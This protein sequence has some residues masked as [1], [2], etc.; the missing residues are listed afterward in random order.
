[1]A[2]DNWSSEDATVPSMPGEPPP[3]NVLAASMLEEDVK[4]ATGQCPR[5]PYVGRKRGTGHGMMPLSPV[6]KEKVENLQIFSSNLLRMQCGFSSCGM[7]NINSPPQ[8]LQNAIRLPLG[9]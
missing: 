8:S 2:V 9:S 3:D 6:C 5:D 1:M 4:S 7:C